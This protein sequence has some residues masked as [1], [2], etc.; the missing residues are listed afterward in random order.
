MTSQVCA[1]LDAV[2]T[3]T[4][5]A[6]EEPAAVVKF[7]STPNTVVLGRRT[8]RSCK[9]QE[10]LFQCRLTDTVVFKLQALPRALH[11]SEQPR[12]A[13]SLATHLIVD[14]AVV[15]ILQCGAGEG[16]FDEV[17]HLTDSL[18]DQLIAVATHHLRDDRVTIAELVLQTLRAAQTLELAVDHDRHA[19][20]Q[21]LALLHTT[22]TQNSVKTC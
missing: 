4:T 5:T 16:L 20:A 9:V 12:P 15:Q 7:H 1:R 6:A 3:A 2:V 21:R 19:R 17:A 18:L 14:V 11:R 22:T 8:L 10:D 13:H